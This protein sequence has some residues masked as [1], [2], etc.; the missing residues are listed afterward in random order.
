MIIGTHHFTTRQA[1]I[2]YYAKQGVNIVEVQYKLVHGEIAIGKPDMFFHT[3]DSSVPLS[4]HHRFVV[5]C[6]PDRDG[7]YHIETK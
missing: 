2:S 6:W 1:A 4:R 7:R 3:S 5:S